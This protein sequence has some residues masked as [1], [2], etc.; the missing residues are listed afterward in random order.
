M[1]EAAIPEATPKVFI[2]Y[3]RDDTSGHAGR[4][5][6]AVAER[7]GDANVFMDVELKPVV[8]AARASRASRTRAI[9]SGSRSRPRYAARTLR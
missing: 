3:R 7:L 6:D 1:V 8:R 9:S 4:V 5:Y 2:S